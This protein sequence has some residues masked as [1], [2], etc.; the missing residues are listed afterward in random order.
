MP[1]V[2]L[3]LYA[4]LDNMLNTKIKKEIYYEHK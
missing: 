3:K 1:I 4:L 2:I